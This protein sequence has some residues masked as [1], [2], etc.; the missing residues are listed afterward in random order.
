[1]QHVSSDLLIWGYKCYKFLQA[2]QVTFKSK[3]DNKSM[4]ACYTSSKLKPNRGGGGGGGMRIQ[5]L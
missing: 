2:L 3:G 1:M 4:Q 5:V